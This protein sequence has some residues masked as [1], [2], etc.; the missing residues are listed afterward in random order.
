MLRK[1]RLGP[2]SLAPLTEMNIG[3][4][5]TPIWTCHRT[6]ESQINVMCQLSNADVVAKNETAQK[7]TI[8]REQEAGE[9]IYCQS[10]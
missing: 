8:Q 5:Q 3:A 2:S 1:E 9:V 4:P 10:P 6:L 7:P